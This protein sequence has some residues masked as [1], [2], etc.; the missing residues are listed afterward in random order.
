LAVW[1]PDKPDESLREFLSGW[2]ADYDPR[3]KMR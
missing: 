2:R 3:S 1:L